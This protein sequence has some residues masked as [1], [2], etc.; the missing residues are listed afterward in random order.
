LAELPAAELGEQLAVLPSEVVTAGVGLGSLQ[1]MLGR[2]TF[3]R[4]AVCFVPRF[5]FVRGVSYAVLLSS[6][7]EGGGVGDVQV[8][9]IQCPALDHDPAAR[10]VAI[11]P[12][13]DQVP[14][15]LLKL[16][17]HFSRPMSEGWAARAIHVRR[18]DTGASL[19]GVFLGVEP[20][21][22]DRERRRLT[23]LLDPARIKR[24]LISHEE[25]GYPL[26][27]GVSFVVT[28]D[29]GFP[30][31][32]GQPLCAAAE[33]CYKVGPPLR[34][35]VKPTDWR[36]HYPASGS[37]DPLTVEFDRPLDH[38]L[39]QHSLWVEDASGVALA[40][41]GCVGGNDQ[42]WKFKPQSPWQQAQYR[43]VADSRL[44]DLAGNSL[45]RVFD[46]DL[47]SAGDAPT[48]ARYAS[49]DFTCTSTSARRDN[50]RSR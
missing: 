43:L 11:H 15:N 20:E 45:M 42:G 10:V 46:R 49:I 44:E 17:V 16:Y 34:L 48:Y 37:M 24:G 28:V 38:A 50:R 2:F 9:T 25:A 12:S 36:C 27:E 19:E 18:A 32:L 1:P 14:V 35:R 22:W 8:P 6:A 23:L 30:D 33:R 5:A 21:L 41:Q 47:M 7:K 31:A 3:D 4:D 13:A 26:K 29:A 39:L 40:G